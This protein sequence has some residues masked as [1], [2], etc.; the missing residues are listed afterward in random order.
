MSD[1]GAAISLLLVILAIIINIILI[2]KFVGLCSDVKAIRKKFCP[3]STDN[4]ANSE[5]STHNDHAKNVKIGEIQGLLNGGQTEE[6]VRRFTAFSANYP[7]H[8]RIPTFMLEIGRSFY[9][10]GNETKAIQWYNE[11][12]ATTRDDQD[13]IK[14][15]ARRELDRWK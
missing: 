6:A 2:V 4:S 15:R 11:A 10:E 12:I 7:D 13:Y 5:V 8:P 1:E 14:A 9:R 3:E